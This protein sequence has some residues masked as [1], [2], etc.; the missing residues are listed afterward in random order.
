MIKMESISKRREIYL[1]NQYNL[2]IVLAGFF[3]ARVHIL[4]SLSPFGIAYLAASLIM[5]RYTV[6]LPLSIGLG[7]YS[8]QGLAGANYLL[9]GL[10]TYILLRKDQGQNLTKI[11]A[12]FLVSMIFLM[13]QLVWNLVEGLNQYSFLTL[14]LE[15]LII[16]TMTYVFTFSFPLERLRINKYKKEQILCSFIVMALILSGFNNI[17]IY[18][19]SLKN[20]ITII[21]VIYLGYSQ[22]VLYGLVGSVLIGLI[23]Y[24]SHI[25]MPFIISILAVGGLLAGLF[26]DIG[27]AGSILGFLLGNGIISFYINRLGTSFFAYKELLFG[28]LVFLAITQFIRL[29]FKDFL[30]KNLMDMDSYEM[31]KEDYLVERLNKTSELFLGLS[32]IL[33]ES[34]DK[35]IQDTSFDVYNTVDEITNGVCKNCRRYS[36]CWEENYYKTYQGVLGLIGLMESGL[37]N[38]NLLFSRV[39]GFCREPRDLIYKSFQSYENLKESHLCSRRLLE[40]RKLL[41]DQMKNFTRIITDI[42]ED[43][44]RKP[45]FHRDLEEELKKELEDK[46]VEIIELIVVEVENK[47]FEIMI[48]IKNSRYL[49]TDINEIRNIVSKSL[50]MDFSIDYNFGNIRDDRIS[51][52]LT[53]TNRFNTYT[54]IAYESNSENLISGDNYTFGEIQNLNF[55]AISDGMGIGQR[56][57]DKSSIAIN[58]IEKSMEINMDKNTIIK[59]INSILRSKSNQEIFTTLDLGFIDLYTGKLQ[60]VK[61]GSPA[62]FIKR[63]DEVKLINSK[64]LPIGILENVDFNIYEEVLQDGDII[65]MMSDGIL[66]S[67]SLVENQEKW[68]GDLIEKIDSQNPQVIVNEIM[69]IARMAN[70]G[71]ERDDMTVMATKIWRNY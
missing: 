71:R 38:T 8:L 56:A 29:D 24:I 51:F 63:K 49:R 37:A 18:G 69:D 32:Q 52:K 68:L 66:E 36:Y 9:I 46:R 58:L 43:V 50:D 65:I 61:N 20:L 4:K 28:S 59:T 12:A 26:R 16:F 44:K 33:R 5:G 15:S 62:T 40:Q 11:K 57:R 21:C 45:I 30:H 23:S 13:G 70:E 22:G 17:H 7:I 34:I 39:E 6:F 14:I 64:S 67:N 60:I 42:K 3:I 19:V 25:E 53:K 2:I 27:R 35:E 54:G 48:E 41:A 1:I 31:K 10:I 55:M 47:K